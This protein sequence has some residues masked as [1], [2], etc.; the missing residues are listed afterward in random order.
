MKQEELLQLID[1]AKA[2]MGSDRQVAI[3]LGIPSQHIANWKSGN[4]NPQPEDIAL[5]ASIAGLEADKWAL[6]AL[7]EKHEGTAKGDLLIKALG[8]GLLATGAA[9]ASVG[10][11]AT[12]I[13]GSTAPDIV[14]SV[15]VR[16]STMYRNV[17]FLARS[18]R[19]EY[20]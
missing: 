13:F 18:S 2:K 4:R 17:K 1:A 8:K 19:E 3:A 14:G 5:L 10:A 16:C 11:H 6:R 20:A 9:I 12:L 15:L 7:I